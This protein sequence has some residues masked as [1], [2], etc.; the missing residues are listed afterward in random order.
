MAPDRG[1]A[2]ARPHGLAGADQHYLAQ[3]RWARSVFGLEDRVE[4]RRMQVYDLADEKRR[5]LLTEPGW[6]KMAFVEH[7]FA[8]DP[9]N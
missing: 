6:P 2:P 8:D 9:T 1:V 5:K 3:A 7:E 4:F